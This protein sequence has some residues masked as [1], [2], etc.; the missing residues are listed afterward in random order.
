MNTTTNTTYVRLHNTTDQTTCKLKL[1]VS[2][3][4][5]LLNWKSWS[6]NLKLEVRLY[7]KQVTAQQNNENQ[8]K[9]L[10]KEKSLLTLLNLSDSKLWA[11]AMLMFRG[12]SP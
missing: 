6:Q 10:E 9:M 7:L 5:D 8:I 1:T 2:E 3:L 11:E 4:F 12:I